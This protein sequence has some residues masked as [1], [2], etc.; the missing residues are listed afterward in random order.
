[1]M[2]RRCGEELEGEE[3]DVEENEKERR[4]RERTSPTIDLSAS[5]S[6]GIFDGG[7]HPKIMKNT[8]SCHN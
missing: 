1:M 3:V 8:A 2:R 5:G 7:E 6:K 4:R